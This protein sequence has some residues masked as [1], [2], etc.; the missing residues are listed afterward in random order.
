MKLEFHPGAESDAREAQSWY[1][2]RSA[3]AARAF[4]TE[5]S[6]A[7]DLIAHAPEAWPSYLAGTR[8]YFLPAF[9]FSVVCRVTES[10]ITVIAV[11]HHRRKPGYWTKR[12]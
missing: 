8:R 2:E 9:P 6:A 12:H 11:A 5:L 3:I 1:S 4:V 10:A 7:I